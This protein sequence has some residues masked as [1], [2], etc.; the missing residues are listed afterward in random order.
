MGVDDGVG[1][2]VAD[3]GQVFI[4]DYVVFVVGPWFKGYDVSVYGSAYSTL[5]SGIMDTGTLNRWVRESGS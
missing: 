1:L 4:D 3:E 2:V 5:D